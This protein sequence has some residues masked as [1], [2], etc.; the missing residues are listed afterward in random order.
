MHHGT[1]LLSIKEMQMLCLL[2]VEV[3]KIDFFPLLEENS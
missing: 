3:I 1:E 2:E